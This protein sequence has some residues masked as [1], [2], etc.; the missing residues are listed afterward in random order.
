MS[1][2]IRESLDLLI[3]RIEALTPKTDINSGFVRMRDGKGL[4]QLIEQN[5]YSIRYF[6]IAPLSMPL[7]DGMLGIST[8]K[9]VSLSLRVFY[10]IPSDPGYLDRITI[11]DTALLI[12]SLKQPD[13]NSNTTGII[14]L[15]VNPAQLQDITNELGEPRANLLTIDFDLLYLE[16]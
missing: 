12:E 4:T 2:G 14:S 3:D 13:Y 1:K 6:D 7:D 5:Y 16:E 10:G 15:V 11:E 9:R 8:R